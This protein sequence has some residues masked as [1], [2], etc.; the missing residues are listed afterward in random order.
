MKKIG[1]AVLKL[2][3]FFAFYIIIF[4]S[5]N[6][7]QWVGFIL[8]FDRVFGVLF[9]PTYQLYVSRCDRVLNFNNIILFTV[10]FIL[11][12]LFFSK[13]MDASLKKIYIVSYS[14]LILTMIG[15]LLPA[16]IGSC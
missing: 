4:V 2:A 14:L 12:W 8:S 16:G 15:R 7:I 11:I 6:V 5:S 9:D 1:N 10:S 3:A 13:K